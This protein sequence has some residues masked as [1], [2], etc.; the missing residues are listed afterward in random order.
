MP[1]R[2]YCIYYY[3]AICALIVLV[4]GKVYFNVQTFYVTL[5]KFYSL[6]KVRHVIWCTNHKIVVV[7]LCSELLMRLSYYIRRAYG[8]KCSTLAGPFDRELSALIA[9]PF[10][11]FC[12][13]HFEHII[14]R[15]VKCLGRDTLTETFLTESGILTDCVAGRFCS[16]PRTWS[17]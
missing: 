3:W 10:N 9:R 5:L 11:V 7:G 1:G 15:C 8:K 17:F 13:A 4:L 6:F 2:Y 12:S 16:W 14:K